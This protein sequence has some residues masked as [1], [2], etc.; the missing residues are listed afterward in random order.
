MIIIGR[1][2]KDKIVIV[3]SRQSPLLLDAECE[4]C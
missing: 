2:L 1:F 4:Y 3:A